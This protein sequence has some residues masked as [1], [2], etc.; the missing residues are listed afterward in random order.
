MTSLSMKRT[1]FEFHGEAGYKRLRCPLFCWEVC[2]MAGIRETNGQTG[3]LPSLVE[4]ED[5]ASI[6][7]KEKKYDGLFGRNI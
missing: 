3:S 5:R 6:G 1:M 4:K 2:G 7:E